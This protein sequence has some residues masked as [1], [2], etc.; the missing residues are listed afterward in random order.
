MSS[1]LPLVNRLARHD[2]QVLVSALAIRVP[3]TIGVRDLFD[4]A[5]ALLAI[6]SIDHG[7]ARLSKDE[8]AEVAA[9]NPSS[10]LLATCDVLLLGDPDH[11]FPEVSERASHWITAVGVASA[12]SS[13]EPHAGPSLANLDDAVAALHEGLVAVSLLDDLLTAV[14][15]VPAR[16]NGTGTLAKASTAH[17]EAVMPRSDTDLQSLVTWALNTP[18]MSSR[19]GTLRVVTQHMAE[20]EQMTTLERWLWLVATWRERIPSAGQQILSATVWTVE[21]LEAAAERRLIVSHAWIMPALIEA[22]STARV[23]GLVREANVSPVALAV[24]GDGAGDADLE[25]VR[26]YALAHAPAE[27]ETFIVQH[28]LSIIAPGPLSA[29][30]SARLRAMSHVESRGMASTFRISAESISRALATGDD[31]E[32]LLAFLLEHSLT[33]LPQ[34]LVYLINDL[35]AKH[36]SVRVSRI[37]GRTMVEAATDQLASLLGVDSNVR[38]LQLAPTGVRTF[39]TVLEPRAVMSVLVEAGYPAVAVDTSPGLE[40]V[41]EE[42]PDA[43]LHALVT[44]LRERDED[45]PMDASWLK[46]QL[47][48]AIRNKQRVTVTVQM[49]DGE[50]DFELE[51]TALANGR[52]RGRD[53]RGAV[54][55]TLPLAFITAVSP[56]L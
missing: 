20:W 19:L 52:L 26:A 49:P 17:L 53:L 22:V 6:P 14:T 56:A 34:N 35:A 8:L 27:V 38:H 31:G 28:D 21:A 43:A 24:L 44:R 12:R 47:D 5:E 29:R 39:G 32:A 4:L 45:I 18:L 13:A 30:D 2:E 48:L 7:L 10:E 37:A 54:E 40:E 11:I 55:R 33:E 23:L 46:R 25:H 50:R 41:P 42:A 36:G 1:A 9:G 3:K 51:V 16:V 15:H